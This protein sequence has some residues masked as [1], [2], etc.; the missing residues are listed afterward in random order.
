M[1][2]DLVIAHR[3]GLGTD[4]GDHGGVGDGDAAGDAGEFIEGRGVKHGLAPERKGGL[5]GRP[6]GSDELDLVGDD[7]GVVVGR[8]SFSFLV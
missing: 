3:S 7:L 2:G 6:S 5:A 4:A 8:P 1:G